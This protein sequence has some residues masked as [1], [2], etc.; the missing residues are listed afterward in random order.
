MRVHLTALGVLTPTRSTFTCSNFL[1][2]RPAS[3]DDT[4]TTTGT[5]LYLVVCP[6]GGAA[7]VKG[8]TQWHPKQ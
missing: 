2:V 8:R 3:L 1:A 7:A 5:V 6:G 4:A